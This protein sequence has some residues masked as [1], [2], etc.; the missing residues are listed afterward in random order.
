MDQNHF[1]QGQQLFAKSLR[2][3]QNGKLHLFSFI[4]CYRRS[5]T[6]YFCE[7]IMSEKITLFDSQNLWMDNDFKVR[8]QNALVKCSDIMCDHKGRLT[9]H[10][11]Y[12]VGQ[13]L[14]PDWHFQHCIW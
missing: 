11:Q 3:K 2:A 9:G 1:E 7:D 4:E 13:C 12:L 10:I 14:M 8:R 5:F 6:M